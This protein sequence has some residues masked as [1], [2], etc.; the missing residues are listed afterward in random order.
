MAKWLILLVFIVSCGPEPAT[1]EFF[2]NACKGYKSKTETP[3][4][5][6][7]KEEPSATPEPSPTPPDYDRRCSEQDKKQ[8][9]ADERAEMFHS[10]ARDISRSAAPSTPAEVKVSFE[11]ATQDCE[12]TRKCS[13][14]ALEVKIPPG[15]DLYQCIGTNN[16]SWFQ[17]WCRNPEDGDQ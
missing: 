1:K 9:L 16:Q 14:V 10:I 13:G 5:E 11:R 7:E 6:R 8:F 3:Q 15:R 12:A 2:D 4:V 17:V